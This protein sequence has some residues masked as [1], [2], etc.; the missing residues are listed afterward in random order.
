MSGYKELKENVID[1]E[2]CTGCGTC[3]GM[4]PINTLDFID[5]QIKNPD[6]KC[7]QCGRCVKSCPGNEFDFQKHNKDLFNVEYEDL[8]EKLGYYK[9]IWSGFST[10]HVV[11][12]QAASGGIISALLAWLLENKLVDG[13]VIIDNDGSPIKYKSKIVYTPEEVLNGA[14]SKY[15]II[16]TNEI[17]KEITKLDGK[18]VYVGLPCQIQGLRKA[19]SIDQ[20]LRNKIYL[21]IG[22]FCGFNLS[23]KATDYLIRK[24]NIEK[25]NTEY[26][27]YRMKKNNMT[28]FYTRDYDGKEFFINKHGYTFLNLIYSPVRCWKCFDYTSEFADIS[29]GDAWE[30]GE[31]WSRIIVRTDKG[32]EIISKAFEANRIHIKLSAQEDIYMS[33]KS[34]LNYKK[35][36][37]GFRKNIMKDFPEN[38]LGNKNTSTNSNLKSFILYVLQLFGQTKICRWGLNLMPIRVLE[39]VSTKLRK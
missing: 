10:D 5:E 27:S 30:Q 18:F 29:V 6:L 23:Y 25:E 31:G 22:L 26:I 3:I 36:G 1:K 7:I 39:V 16:P 2:L 20:N 34:I 15:M 35:V 38:N 37:F 4:C 11:R 9:E 19:M 12:N 32:K 17:I 24:G 33:Q 13:A 14:Q 28:G 21:T 8:N